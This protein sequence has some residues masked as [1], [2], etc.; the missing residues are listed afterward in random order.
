MGLSDFPPE[1]L[2]K[3]FLQLSYGSLLSVTAVCVQWNAIV[4]DDPALRVQMFKKLSK[5]YVEP[6]CDEPIREGYFCDSS[7]PG[8]GEPIRLHPAVQMASCN[9]G[10]DEPSV[11]FI[12]EGSFPRLKNLAIADDF[13]SIP[14]IT[15]LKIEIEIPD[16]PYHGGFK[17]KVKNSK[18]VKL[19]DFFTELKREL[20]RE[21]L[22]QQMGFMTRGE[23]LGNWVLYKGLVK[24]VKTGLGCSAELSV[25]RFT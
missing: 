5:V 6:G 12:S 8:A 10:S 15:M 9:M 22:T 13:I 3:I 11:F 24:I 21:V 16:T 19:T 14:V 2:T 25:G 1:L 4:T 7:I 20:T 18:G 17:F 23:L